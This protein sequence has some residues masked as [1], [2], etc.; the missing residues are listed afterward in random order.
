MRSCPCGDFRRKKAIAS[1]RLEAGSTEY[2]TLTEP[3]GPVKFF[4]KLLYGIDMYLAKPYT[5]G[6][7]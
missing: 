2:G 1:L 7:E 4:K 3:H 5:G 6:H